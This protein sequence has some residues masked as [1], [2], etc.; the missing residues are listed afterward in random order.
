LQTDEA[1]LCDLLAL[2]YACELRAA[3][4]PRWIFAG[5]YN[6]S[7]CRRGGGGSRQRA[8]PH[9]AKEGVNVNTT[10]TNTGGHCY[11]P[12]RIHGKDSRATLSPAVTQ[13]RDTLYIVQTFDYLCTGT[14][15][16]LLG[17]GEVV[18]VVCFTAAAAQ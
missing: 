3:V 6:R 13:I 10:D 8:T 2:N 5:T 17:G 16:T 4:R 11:C 15:S 1:G 7:A 18:C 9:L 14:G 12:L